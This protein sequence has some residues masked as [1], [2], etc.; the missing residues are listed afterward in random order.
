MHW[1]QFK[2]WDWAG[3]GYLKN[4]SSFM[5]LH[6]NVKHHETNCKA[7][8]PQLW[9][10]Y[11]WSSSYCPLDIEIAYMEIQIF[12]LLYLCEEQ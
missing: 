7:Q 11:C 9:I 1:W 3:G 4:T 6:V 2:G 10:A 8:E 12:M 5:K